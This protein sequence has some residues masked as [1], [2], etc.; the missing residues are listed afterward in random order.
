MFG[1][2]ERRPD[3]TSK[4]ISL[5][6]DLIKQER[7]RIMSIIEENPDDLDVNRQRDRFI[8]HLDSIS[9]KLNSAS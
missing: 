7:A 4:D 8:A 2:K 1:A 6:M 5:L 9:R 3:I